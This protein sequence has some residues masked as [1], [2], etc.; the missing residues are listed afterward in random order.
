MGFCPWGLTGCG[1]DNSSVASRQQGSLVT[2]LGGGHAVPMEICGHG[3]DWRYQAA[4]ARECGLQ[5]LRLWS[6][7]GVLAGI[8]RVV[9]L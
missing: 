1:F 6:Q 8:L 2:G 4:I 9:I 3:A 7:A 5:R